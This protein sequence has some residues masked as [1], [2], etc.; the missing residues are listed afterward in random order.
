MPIKNPNLSSRPS[1][2]NKKY[3]QS[4]RTQNSNKRKS[5]SEDNYSQDLIDIADISHGLVFLNDGSIVKILEIVP[6][7]FAERSDE[8]KDAIADNFGY[9]FKQFPKDGHLKIMGSKANLDSF[10]HKLSDV[11][12]KE[13]DPRFHERVI[14]HIEKTKYLQS[15][16]STK[17]RFFY[18]FSYEGDADGRKTDDLEDILNEM[19]N[20]QL[21]IANAFRDLGNAVL[22][23]DDDN[24]YVADILYT[25]FNP[26]SF[27]EEGLK[28]RM[29]S[30]QNASSYLA[31][32][33]QSKLPPTVDYLAPRGTKMKKWDYMVTDGIYQTYLALRDNSF[34]TECY[35]GWV[36]RI[37]NAPQVADVDIHYHQNIKE[38]AMTI[39]D[40]TSIIKKG[41]AINRAGDTAKQQ[42]LMGE[43]SNADYL[44]SCLRDND[45][46]LYEVHLMVTIKGNT[47]KEMNNNKNNFL[48]SMKQLSLYFDECFL[49]TQD[50][51]KMA[52]PLNY[53]ISSVFSAN[54]RNMTNSSLS[55]LYCLT[56]FEMYDPSGFCLGTNAKNGT[57]FSI[58]NFNRHMFPNPHIFI[59]GTTGAGKSFFEMMLSSRMRMQGITTI[60]LLPLKGYEYE[61]TV[62][63]Y[64]GSFISLKPGG[65][66]C[67]NIMEI[68]PEG[69]ADMDE[70]E[71]SEIQQELAHHAPL[72]AK[73][74]TS[75]LTFL[76]L[77][78]GTNLPYDVESELNVA[79]Y[80]VYNKYGINDDNLSIYEDFRSGTIK[81]MPIIGDLYDEIKG[82]PKL[83][84]IASAL[85]VW[86][87]GNCK[88]MNGHTN[89]DLT[90]KMIAF[91]I[92]ED[93]IGTRYLP[94]FM[95]LAFDVA[96]DI[97]KKDLN[98]PVAI[99]LDE[100]WKMLAIPSCGEQ[101]F[102]M[103]KIIRAY[104]ACA[105]SATQD[106]EDCADNEYGRSILTLSAIKI[107]LHAEK[108]EIEK[109]ALSV[110]LSPVNRREILNMPVGQ[111]FLCFNTERIKINLIP[112]LLEEQLYNPKPQKKA[113]IRQKRLALNPN[114]STLF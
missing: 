2:V 111:G 82:N 108:E 95:Y 22:N 43:A 41:I 68:R 103:I 93:A 94:A 9:S 67:L 73:K 4:V 63:S 76:S 99:F 24:N 37:M 66:A 16:N 56:S 27:E 88:N 15:M 49:K 83:A 77:L 96:Y 57:L 105:V 85:R 17:K 60:F 48:K 53:Q 30:V 19:W 84:K 13:T 114:K 106:I 91:D 72:L 1:T 74:V 100:I 23:A 51:F 65:Q 42:D 89:V 75:I 78:T 47:W 102:K 21:L 81:K 90:N 3:E 40:R 50:Y 61:D 28:R 36:E 69:I 29:Q 44:L 109:L 52:M 45:E 54:T 11:A 70:A 59:A 25:Y 86:V 38:T 8:E 79:L 20:T 34:P 5:S 7:N 101:I 98:E 97:A 80:R 33:G 10:I 39:I 71:D 87:E 58:N 18:I 62:N 55:S 46:D 35:V 107:F 104:N 113:E 26:R 14:D 31:R 112:S 32:N 64:G 6:I 12:K 92:N 110:D